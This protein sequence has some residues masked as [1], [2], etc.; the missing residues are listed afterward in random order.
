MARAKFQNG[1]DAAFFTAKENTGARVT[2][3]SLG[4]AYGKDRFFEG[5]AALTAGIL[6][7][8]A[9]TYGQ[10]DPIT[11]EPRNASTLFTYLQV[12]QH[13]KRKFGKNRPV[14][15]TVDVPIYFSA[16]FEK[17]QTSRGEWKPN[18]QGDLRASPNVSVDFKI[19]D[20]K[21]QLRGGTSF[22]PGLADVR[23]LNSPTLIQEY[24]MAGLHVSHE[25]YKNVTMDHDVQWMTDKTGGQW[26]DYRVDVKGETVSGFAEFEGRLTDDTP[27]YR[28]SSVRTA[29]GGVGVELGSVKVV[30][31]VQVPVEMNNTPKE[32]LKASRLWLNPSFD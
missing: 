19:L 21:V 3:I 31:S 24:F 17:D 14:S 5:R 26:G 18:G 15:V 9:K 7:R 8:P 28:D 4:R 1:L 10:V 12:E 2:G 32:T 16:M 6:Q 13:L 20:T 25:L 11:F 22:V 29:E 27:F 23:M 30:G